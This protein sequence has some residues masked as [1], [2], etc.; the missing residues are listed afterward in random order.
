MLFLLWLLSL[1]TVVILQIVPLRDLAQYQ[2]WSKH[3]FIG[4]ILST[5]DLS[6]TGETPRNILDPVSLP[7]KYKN[8]LDHGKCK[9]KNVNHESTLSKVSFMMALEKA[10]KLMFE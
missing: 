1:K 9:E 3:S 7:V 2:M 4:Q 8:M 5:H 6:G 10:G